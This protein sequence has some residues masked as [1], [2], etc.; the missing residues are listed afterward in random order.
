MSHRESWKTYSLQQ[1]KE[2]NDFNSIEALIR[3][4]LIKVPV[5]VIP[6]CKNTIPFVS[7]EKSI[8]E[9]TPTRDTRSINHPK[10]DSQMSDFIKFRDLELERLK[11]LEAKINQKR[12]QEN[13]H[14]INSV[15]G[16][17]VDKR[18]YSLT[19]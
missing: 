16:L 7:R 11:N 18:Y 1:I 9:K 12:N 5:A 4:S 17:V 14:F 3:E 19:Q 8:L 13:W 6:T 10:H 2:T 15:K